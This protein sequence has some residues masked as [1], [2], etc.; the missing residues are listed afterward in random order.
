MVMGSDAFTGNTPENDPS[1]VIARG[2]FLASTIYV[3]TRKLFTST[4]R[5]PETRWL[6]QE[7]AF[8]GKS[9]LI[10]SDRLAP[11]LEHPRLGAKG[12]IVVAIVGICLHR[13]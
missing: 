10:E 2:D 11:G 6:R 3:N 8:R 4:R 1:N 13:V 9:G 5:F 7:P 12:V